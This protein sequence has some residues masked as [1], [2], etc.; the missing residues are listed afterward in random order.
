[1]STRS[2]AG[3]TLDVVVG[4]NTQ[5]K[6][7]RRNPGDTQSLDARPDASSKRHL[8]RFPS[9]PDRRRPMRRKSLI[10]W[11][12]RAAALE[13]GFESRWGHFFDFVDV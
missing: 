7:G 13:H 5:G 9:P 2:R 4:P 3:P 10:R 1:V 6:D 11:Q 8:A 12:K